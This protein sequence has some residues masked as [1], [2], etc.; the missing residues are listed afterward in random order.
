[1]ESQIG[2]DL[3]RKLVLEEKHTNL[4]TLERIMHIVEHGEVEATTTGIHQIDRA[5]KWR[6]GETNIWTGYGN[7]GKS[8]FLNFL[9]LVKC[10]LDEDEKA[11]IFSP[12]NQP[13]EFFYLDFIHTILGRKPMNSDKDKVVEIYQWLKKNIFFVYP[14]DFTLEKIHDE[15][16]YLV[17]VKGVTMCIVDPYLK[18]AHKYDGLAEHHYVGRFMTTIEHFAREHQVSYHVVA[19]QNTPHIV[20]PAVDFVKRLGYKIKGGGSFYDGADN[21]MI[22]WRPCRTSNYQDPTVVFESQK[23]KKQKIVAR[24][25]TIDMKF[26]FHKQRYETSTGQDMYELAVNNDLGF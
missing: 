26:N 10:K 17:E 8:A 19:H 7:E 18:V 15:M 4:N 9:T 2:N 16:K 6:K 22:V 11:A 13:A 5:W 14:D 12:E 1:L 24:P 23:I 25:N 3:D 21:V 20:P